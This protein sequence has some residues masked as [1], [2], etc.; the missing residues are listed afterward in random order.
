MISLKEFIAA[1]VA[2]LVLSTLAVT[3]PGQANAAE[4]CARGTLDQQYCD[5]DGDL[6]ADL[7]L[8]AA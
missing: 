2:M 1:A 4:D 8:D 6:V 3:A 5:R 7:P